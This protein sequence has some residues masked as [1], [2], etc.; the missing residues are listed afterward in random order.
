MM[1]R[2]LVALGA[3]AATE[4]HHPLP[5]HLDLVGKLGVGL[6]GHVPCGRGCIFASLCSWRLG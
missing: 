4:S 2:G 5:C 1:R 6:A 3:C